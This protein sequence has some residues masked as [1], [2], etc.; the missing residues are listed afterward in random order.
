MALERGSV[1]TVPTDGRQWV[2]F[3]EVDYSLN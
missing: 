3:R 2:S 1:D